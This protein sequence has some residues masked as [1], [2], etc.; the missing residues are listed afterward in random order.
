MRKSVTIIQA[1]TDKRLFGSLLDLSTW[2]SWLVFLKAVFGL[3][4]TVDE[5]EVFRQCTGREWTNLSISGFKE[6]Y[7]IVGRRGG[8]SRIVA[9]ALV[10]LA[11]F[12]EFRRYLAPGE[13]AMALCLARDREQSRV[14]FNYV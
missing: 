11:C 10:Y 4:I 8:K 7:A 1:L 9:F 12:F 2:S 5:L 3:P 6:A 13:R 14:V